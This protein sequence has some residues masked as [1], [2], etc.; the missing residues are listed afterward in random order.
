MVIAKK[1]AAR[2]SVRLMGVVTNLIDAVRPT[3][4]DS[5]WNYDIVNKRLKTKRYHCH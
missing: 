5:A 2:T 4:M 3:M 1:Q